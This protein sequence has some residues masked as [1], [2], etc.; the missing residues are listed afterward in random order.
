MNSVWWGKP[1]SQQ[2][3]EAGG[4]EAQCH[5]RLQRELQP[6]ISYTSRGG[7]R[8][9]LK[10]TGR[11]FVYP[12]QGMESPVL[13]SVEFSRGEKGILLSSLHPRRSLEREADMKRM[14]RK[15]AVVARCPFRHL[16]PSLPSPKRPTAPQFI[17]SVGT[18][19]KALCSGRTHSNFPSCGSVN[20]SLFS[21]AHTFS[22]VTVCT[23]RS[24]FCRVVNKPLIILNSLFAAVPCPSGSP[25]SELLCL[26][27]SLFSP[28][29]CRCELV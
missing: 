11:H 20:T 10:R 15:V 17:H 4:A 18:I 27:F 21:K 9:T 3:V 1:R 16:E 25:N 5:P 2:E 7:G 28:R 26:L 29:L 12:S 8:T 23:D 14:F 19:P 6:G 24:F 13:N 22:Y